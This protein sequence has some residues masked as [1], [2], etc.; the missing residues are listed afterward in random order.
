MY[1]NRNYR[2]SL[3]GK[4]LKSFRVSVKETDLH[5][6]VDTGSYVPELEKKAEKQVISLRYDLDRYISLD[7]EFKTTLRPHALAPGAPL[8]AENMAWAANTAGIGP[9]AAVAGAFAEY[10]GR[11]LL[12]TVREVI[13]ENGGDIFM[14]AAEKRLVAIFAGTSPFSNR[15][16]VEVPVQSMPVGICTSSGTIGPSLSFGQADAAVIIAKSAA[17]A[18]AVATAACNEVHGP[19][20]VKKGI[21]LASGIPGVMGAVIIKDDQLAAWGDINLVPVNS[22]NGNKIF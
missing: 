12:K 20:E 19:K 7:P 6:S 10:I 13:V 14:S 15:I 22:F 17:L 4:N 1:V 16:A 8:I 18:D 21:V 5:I 9:M 2:E 3:I 11:E